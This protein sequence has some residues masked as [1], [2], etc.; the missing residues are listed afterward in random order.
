MICTVHWRSHKEVTELIC[1]CM[2]RLLFSDAKSNVPYYV[3]LL[4]TVGDA[5]G[6]IIKAKN[7]RSYSLIFLWQ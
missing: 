7:I 2:L 1:R 6:P 3:T 4:F 5:L